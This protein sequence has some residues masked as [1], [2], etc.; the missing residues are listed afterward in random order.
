M[1]KK[2]AFILIITIVVVSVV[3]YFKKDNITWDII[4]KNTFITETGDREL[5]SDS[6]KLSKKE[7]EFYQKTADEGDRVSQ[8]I[9]GN[10]YY[11]GV[12]YDQS[13]EKAYEYFSLSA[14]KGYTEAYIALG[15]MYLMGKFVEQS[16]TKSI[17]WYQKAADT[18]NTD[19]L[20]NIGVSYY[21]GDVYEQDYINAEDYLKR[22]A[23]NGS[24]FA[25]L[26]LG[27]CYIENTSPI[28]NEL[29]DEEEFK[30]AA[31]AGIEVA[32]INLLEYYLEKKKYDEAFYWAE[33]SAGAK[34]TE[35]VRLGKYYLAFFYEYGK[36]VDKD[37]AMAKSLFQEAQELG[38]DYSE[39]ISRVENEIE[40]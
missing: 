31:E 32:Y 5:P 29:K 2:I 9:I 10:L 18:G 30:L 20:C 33:K 1:K 7:I 22:A 38:G 26:Y 23:D 24:D 14:E 17:D 12:F 35:V 39:D 25:H 8:Y 27:Y 40:E 3:I 19:G 13:Y 21:R 4:Q 36:M 28:V 37:L 34:D 16:N 15:D 11:Y 6:S